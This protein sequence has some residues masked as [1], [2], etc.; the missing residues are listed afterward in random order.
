MTSADL[1]RA[2]STLREPDRWLL[3]ARRGEAKESAAELLANHGSLDEFWDLGWI[4][5][6]PSAVSRRAALRAM[7]DILARV[8]A[9]DL[10]WRDERARNTCW[11][12]DDDAVSPTPVPTWSLDTEPLL[13]ALM[14]AA[15]GRVRERAV[16]AFEAARP[17]SDPAWFVL[18]A[19]LDDW[20]PQVRD[21]AQGVLAG[22]MPELRPEQLALSAPAVAALASRRRAAAGGVLPALLARMR[23]SDVVALLT[24][25]LGSSDREFRRGVL[26]F[27]LECEV[28]LTEDLVRTALHWQDPVIAGR[29]GLRFLRAGAVDAIQDLLPHLLAAGQPHLRAMV[30]D[31]MARQLPSAA[32]PVLTAALLDRADAVR[33]VSVFQLERLA[34]GVAAGALRAALQQALTSR[35]AA[36]ALRS[37]AL[38]SRD[39]RDAA[40]IRAW[41][42]DPRAPVAAAALRAL[43]SWPVAEHA[44]LFRRAAC[45]PRPRVSTTAADVLLARP[46]AALP[47][48]TELEASPLPHHRRNA[49]RLRLRAAGKWHRLEAILR[50]I[51]DPHDGVRRIAIRRLEAWTAAFNRS[52]ADADD[53]QLARCKALLDRVCSRLEQ[54][55]AEQIRLLL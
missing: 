12:W 2:L 22:A 36:A 4:A 35:R 52:F 29:I 7:R 48:I 39:P 26:R 43:A 16:Q 27:A 54:P 15:D 23:A 30:L 5:S 10:F 14:A 9:A 51:G 11:R 19:R 31:W 45:S 24:R 38:A 34:P 47:V 8:R 40:T 55:L 28:E 50:T 3:R 53:A 46:D 18:L 32:R 41:V 49:L 13:V 20:V 42:D 17:L 44:D 37:L 33:A 6:G 21:A 1:L 25:A